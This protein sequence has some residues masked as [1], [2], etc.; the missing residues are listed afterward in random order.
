VGIVDAVRRVLVGAYGIPEPR[1]GRTTAGVATFNSAVEPVLGGR[2]FAKV[3]RAVG[4]H[5]LLPTDTLAAYAAD[6]H[7]AVLAL[8]EDDEDRDEQLRQLLA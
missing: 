5:A 8:W 1:L 4:P 3:Y 7:A 6:R 2:L